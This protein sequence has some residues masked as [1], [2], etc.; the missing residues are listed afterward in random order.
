MTTTS[1]LLLL[2]ALL[3]LS[4]V[5]S[6][7]ETAFFS[8]RPWRIERLRRD[9]PGPGRIIADALRDPRVFLVSV[10]AGTE[11]VNVGSSNV[12]AVLRR[13]YEG[14]FLPPELSFLLGVVAT[15]GLLVL[16]CEVGPKTLAASFPEDVALR[17]A[18]PIGFFLKLARPLTVPLAGLTSFLTE[19]H[20]TRQGAAGMPASLSE[21]DLR[22][23][24]EISAREGILKPSQ[25]EMIE[26]AFRLGDLQVRQ[27]MVPRPDIVAIRETASPEEALAFIRESRHSR[28][29][30]Y[31]AGIDDIAGILYAK[32]L[33]AQRFNLKPTVAVRELARPALFVPE[34]MR[35]RQLVRELQARKVHLA[36]VVDE[37]GGTAG[38]VTLEDLLEE[39]VGE[40]TDKFDRPVR[41][42]RRVRKGLFWVRASMP[43]PEF[44]RKVRTRIKDPEVDT[45]GGYVLKLFDRVPAE[46]D[47]VSDDIFIFTVR[48]MKGRRIMVLM[49][50]RRSGAAS[51]DVGGGEGRKEGGPTDS[52]RAGRRA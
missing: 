27:V 19:R 50:Q 26:S 35:A 24:I 28:V 16:L 33:L 34:M 46:G 6:A 7:S 22:T 42:F 11:L 47:S 21:D 43:I 31:R 49:V 38:V 20:A 37:Y 1:L 15:S 40:F 39:M 10:I 25:T 2:A 45:I 8:L 3:A 18:R 4:A 14:M 5:I 29:P 48:R 52:L 17:L 12:V 32:D 23:L 44:N 51:G 30:V 36:V 41:V 9:K 13:R